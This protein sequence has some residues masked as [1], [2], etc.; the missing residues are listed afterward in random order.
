MKTDPLG[1]QALPIPLP[2]PPPAGGAANDPVF[3]PTHGGG[4]GCP[5]D[6]G[7]FKKRLDDTYIAL[8]RAKRTSGLLMNAT[9][10]TLHEAYFWVS[11]RNYQAQCGP[12]TPPYPQEPDPD[13][14]HDFYGK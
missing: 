13:S 14:I 11:V 4:G 8:Q 5:P 6:C 10:N 9:F 2:L 7:E 3:G 12:Y 1:L